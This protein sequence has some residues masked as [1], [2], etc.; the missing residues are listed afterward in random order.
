MRAHHGNHL[1]EEQVEN[2]A[3]EVVCLKQESEVEHGEAR[4]GVAHDQTWQRLRA[5]QHRCEPLEQPRPVDG[6]TMLLQHEVRGREMAEEIGERDLAGHARRPPQSTRPWGDD[7]N[8]LI[9]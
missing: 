5:R 3:N 9:G 4:E 1:R 6:G 8:V 2:I 7:G